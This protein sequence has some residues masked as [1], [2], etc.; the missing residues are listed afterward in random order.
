MIVASSL[1][2]VISVTGWSSDAAH[3]LGDRTAVDEYV[4]CSSRRGA[5]VSW[6]ALFETSRQ[7][8]HNGPMTSD[9]A[10]VKA[11]VDYGNASG[12][13]VRLDVEIAHD[14]LAGRETTGDRWAACS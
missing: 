14:A 5:C 4:S 3:L 6:G 8:L 10:C 12:Y 2:K 1:V 9:A 11:N 7:G 13:M